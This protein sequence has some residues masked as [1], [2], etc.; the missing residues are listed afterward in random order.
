MGVPPN[1]G[2]LV[3]NLVNEEGAPIGILA[4]FAVLRED[5]PPHLHLEDFTRSLELA[6]TA[7]E[8]GDIEGV[9]QL[10]AAYHRLVDQDQ[11]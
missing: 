11:S 10:E 5:A 6:A 8:K 3:P 2:E 7:A 1:Q 4:L 9:L